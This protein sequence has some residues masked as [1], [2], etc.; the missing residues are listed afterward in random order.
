MNIAL[1]NILTVPEY[2]AWAQAQPEKLRAELIN[3]HIVPMASERAIHNRLK[4]RCY[5]ALAEALKASQLSGEVFIDGMTVP[6]DPYTAYEP[7]VVLYL[8]PRVADE[9]L[10]VSSPFIVV[11][12][13]SPTTSH[14]DRTAKLAGYFT[15]PSVLHYLVID[16]D[17]MR[18]THHQRGA[19]G[20]LAAATPLG[21]TL[22]LD[23]PGID[24]N[25][26]S[27][28]AR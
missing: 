17:T 3:G 13:L 1:R 16:P 8:G 18:L 25:L 6:I 19:D 22:R 2:L 20:M 4:L 11:E 7:D 5:Q 21:D 10:T 15:L 23:P 14:T 12:V 28:F 26:A 9:E 27:I 24:V